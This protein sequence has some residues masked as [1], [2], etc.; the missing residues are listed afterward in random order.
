MIA[1]S[2]CAT[3]FKPNQPGR[4]TKTG[5]RFCSTECYH[6]AA[7]TDLKTRF[8]GY[9]VR[10]KSEECWLWSGAKTRFGYGQLTTG[11]REAKG[12]KR[13]HHISWFLHYGLWP[14]PPLCHTCD[15]RLC[16]NP[17]HLY[18]GTA[19]TNIAD[20][21]R[22]GRIRRKLTP[23]KVLEIR[24][25][26]KEGYTHWTLARMYG[27]GKSAIGDI[28]TGRCWGWLEPKTTQTHKHT[29]PRH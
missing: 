5:K 20:A 18:E 4:K 6:N 14:K 16:V 21:V 29:G 13:A 27:M 10:G 22:R 1:C 17:N 23:E 15:V 7:R 3:K 8:W 12:V 24:R 26:L 25:K 9:C 2:H 11:Y 19:K 28:G